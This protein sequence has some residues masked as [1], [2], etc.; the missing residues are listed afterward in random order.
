MRGSTPCQKWLATVSE[1]AVSF[2][3]KVRLVSRGS[4]QFSKMARAFWQKRWTHLVE[5][6]QCTASH[7]QPI[8]QKIQLIYLQFYNFTHPFTSRDRLGAGLGSGMLLSTVARFCS[9]VAIRQ[10]NPLFRCARHTFISKC[11]DLY[12]LLFYAELQ[13]HIES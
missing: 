6:T 5:T 1:N 4:S 8:V 7:D 2:S 11:Y 12:V 3:K 10:C 13:K 9:I